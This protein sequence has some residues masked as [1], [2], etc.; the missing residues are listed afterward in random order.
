VITLTNID[1]RTKQALA[2]GALERIETIEEI[3]PER[4]VDFVV[5]RV[6]SLARKAEAAR[7]RDDTP[8]REPFLPPEP[9]L[10]VGAIGPA[11]VAVLNKYP[12]IDRH[13]LIVTREF[14]PQ[15]ALI[16]RAD[17]A[18]LASVM[19]S[20][21]GLGFYN[22]GKA[23]GASQPHKHLQVVPLPLGRG[24][25]PFPIAPWLAAA[26]LVDGFGSVPQFDFA[27]ALARF[28]PATLDAADAAARLEGT[29][30]VLLDRVDIEE[31]A[32]EGFAVQSAPYN[33]LVGRDWMLVVR[34]T[35][36]HAD[37]ISVNTLGYAGS[38]FV[39]DEAQL[40]LVRRIGPLAVL[41]SVAAPVMT[42]AGSGS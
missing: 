39:R 31:E 33:L 17:F 25:V 34:R 37:G 35:R 3:L 8:G 11:H 10:T 27:H 19:G 22:G 24:D 29:Y 41:R 6:S 14:A 2:C 15:E 7:P 13:L 30:R 9:E 42:G 1:A 26:R 12:V 16:D 4:G 18:A 32:A 20:F 5:R 28:D 38:L 36:E 21:A 23:G 40:A